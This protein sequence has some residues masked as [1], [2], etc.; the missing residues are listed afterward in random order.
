MNLPNKIKVSKDHIDDDGKPRKD[1]SI[2]K[3]YLLCHPDTL[4]IAIEGFKDMM[5][6][7]LEVIDEE[8][9]DN[10]SVSQGQG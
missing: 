9:T 1:V 10:G 4:P 7:D 6:M 2:F 3:D 5:G 8:E